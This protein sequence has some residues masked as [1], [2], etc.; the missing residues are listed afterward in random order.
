LSETHRDIE[1][2]YY[3]SEAGY[4]LFIIVMLRAS[5]APRAV[6]EHLMRQPTYQFAGKHLRRLM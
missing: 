5:K 6:F 4:Y 3:L 1:E 2:I